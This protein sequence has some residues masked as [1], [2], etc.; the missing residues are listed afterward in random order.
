MNNQTKLQQIKMS[1]TLGNI[2]Y[3]EAKIQAQP[4]IDEMNI[5]G[6]EIAKEHGRTFRKFTF[7][8]IMR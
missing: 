5:R 2:T 6:A 1:M 7:T 3:D 8:G 4:I